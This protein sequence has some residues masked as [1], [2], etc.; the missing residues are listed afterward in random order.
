[1]K[2]GRAFWGFEEGM[3]GKVDEE[4]EERRMFG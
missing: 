3:K 1:M 2:G 4:E